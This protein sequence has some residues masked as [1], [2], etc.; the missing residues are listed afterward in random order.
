MLDLITT[1]GWT[2]VTLCQSVRWC[3]D[4]ASSS[5]LGWL[6]V[7]LISRPSASRCGW[8]GDYD[9]VTVVHFSD[10]QTTSTCREIRY[11]DNINENSKSAHLTIA[12]RCIQLINIWPTAIYSVFDSVTADRH[13]YDNNTWTLYCSNWL[14]WLST[15]PKVPRFQYFIITSTPV[16]VSVVNSCC[17]KP[18]AVLHLTV[19][20]CTS[21]VYYTYNFND[22]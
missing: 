9:W 10:G 14:E 5:W 2:T 3:M 6:A 8:W 4:E 17:V 22:G 11:K 16:C 7:C 15:R 18:I 20:G 21:H 12:E 19:D 13:M 1:L